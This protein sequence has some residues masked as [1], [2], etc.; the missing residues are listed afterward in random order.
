MYLHERLVVSVGYLHARFFL[1]SG[2]SA[3]PHYLVKQYEKNLV[4]L[5]VQQQYNT[6][7]PY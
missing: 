2:G 3:L 5:L 6:K 4:K 7:K 1:P